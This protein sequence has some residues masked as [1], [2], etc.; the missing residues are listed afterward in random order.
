MLTNIF[1]END[2]IFL[3]KKGVALCIFAS[4]FNVWFMGRWLK[5]NIC[6][7]IYSAVICWSG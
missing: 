7:C 2:Y 5:F 1:V 3:S 6:F 4:H